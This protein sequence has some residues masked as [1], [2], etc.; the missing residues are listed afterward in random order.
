VAAQRDQL[1]L[2]ELQA[3]DAP[4]EF[5]TENGFSILRSWEIDGRPAPGDGTYAFVVR[6]EDNSEREIIVT[7]AVEIISDI[8]WRTAGRIGS[9]SSFWIG[10]AERHLAEC[11]WEKDDYPDGNKLAVNQLDPDEI[12]S[13]LNWKA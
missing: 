9:F 4:I 7:I 11:L 10:C 5:L 13:A 6:N 8:R 12:I 2:D 1:E 3:L